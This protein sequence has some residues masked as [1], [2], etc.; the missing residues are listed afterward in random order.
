MRE[1]VR[2]IIWGGTSVDAETLNLFRTEAF[3]DAVF[4]GA[5]G[6]TMMGVAPQ[7]TPRPGDL[8]PCVFR[9][10]YPYTVVELVDVDEPSKPVAEDAEGR[11]KITALTRD[12]FLPPTLE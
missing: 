5:Y 10:F 8:A 11:V 6:N 3:P 1:K 4:A 9:P 7:R 12:F 2:G